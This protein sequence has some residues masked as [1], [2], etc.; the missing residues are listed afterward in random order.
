MFARTILASIDDA[1]IALGV[2]PAG[3]DEWS[4]RGV[5]VDFDVDGGFISPFARPP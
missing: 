5:G 2:R 3:D 1:G 4:L